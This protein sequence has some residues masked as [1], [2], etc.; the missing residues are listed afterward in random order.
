M[1]TECKHTS[2]RQTEQETYDNR[3][4]PIPYE[5]LSDMKNEAE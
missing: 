3:I 5:E 2:I 4:P 1:D